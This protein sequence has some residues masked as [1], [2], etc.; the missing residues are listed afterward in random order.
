MDVLIAIGVL[1][2]GILSHGK[3]IA[4]MIIRG[5]D[6]SIYIVDGFQRLGVL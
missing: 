4:G 2:R 3:V 5:S 6:F 1:I